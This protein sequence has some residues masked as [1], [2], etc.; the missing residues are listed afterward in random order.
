MAI[1]GTLPKGV[2]K[3]S[4]LDAN[5]KKTYTAEGQGIVNLYFNAKIQKGDTVTVTLPEGVKYVGF[6][7]SPKQGES[8]IYCP[9]GTF[10]YVVP[11]VASMATTISKGYANTTNYITARILTDSELA[12]KRNLAENAY[13]YTNNSSIKSDITSQY[14]HATASS[15]WENTKGS[16]ET[17]FLAR[18]AI[19]GFKNCHGHGTYPVQSW[20]PANSGSQW[21]MI[22]FGRAVNVEELGVVVRYDVGHDTW[23]KKATVEVTFEDG[24]TATQTIDIAWTGYEQIIPLN[25]DKPV[26]SIKLKNLTAD[27][28]GGWAAFTE[29]AVYGTEVTK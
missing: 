6:T 23:F 16:G 21:I 3:M 18:N 17:D 8:I 5:V 10:T 14:P 20:G 29:L 28:A 22:D 11:N 19:D 15:E 24:K 26:K 1:A 25:F 2:I 9:D 7:L 12:E 27:K 4:Y 13:D